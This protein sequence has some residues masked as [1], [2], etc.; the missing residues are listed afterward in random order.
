MQYRTLDMHNYPRKAHF[1]FFNAMQNPYVGITAQTDV[2][3]I[4][5]KA[6]SEGLPLF[7][8]T[9]FAVTLAANN[10]PELRQRVTDG[11]IIEYER[12]RPSYTLALDDGTYCY[13]TI[14]A[15]A[16][17]LS[18]FIADGSREQELARSAKSLT[19]S[20]GDGDLLFISC[21]P[22]LSYTDISQPTPS[23]ADY[24][25]RITWGRIYP[26]GERMLMPLSLLAHHALVDG[27]HISRFFE[28][29]DKATREFY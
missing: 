1:D 3:P 5:R 27:I 9:L 12:C 16:K 25:P 26:Q 23:P 8:S 19:D 29:F 20:E 14:N 7:L 17:E 21:I 10:V 24:F 28:G 22:W 2:T 13:C 4:Y 18:G 15:E 6:K 11:N